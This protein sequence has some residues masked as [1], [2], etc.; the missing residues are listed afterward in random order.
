MPPG[1]LIVETWTSDSGKAKIVLYDS[2]SVKLF[3]GSLEIELADPW[4]PKSEPPA[5]GDEPQGE[6]G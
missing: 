6:G 4:A 2:G 3:A 1:A 5:G